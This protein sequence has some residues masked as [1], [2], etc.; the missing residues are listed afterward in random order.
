MMI[1]F[2]L[3]GTLCDSKP[4]IQHSLACALVQSGYPVPSDSAIRSIIGPPFTIG[5]PRIGVRSEDIDRVI[6]SYR[7]RYQ[8]VGAFEN[9][10]YPGIEDVLR[11]LQSEGHQLA[12]ATSKPEASA[13]PIL[14]HFNLSRY[15]T[16]RAGATLDNSRSAKADVIQYALNQFEARGQQPDDAGWMIG[17]R[18]HD[19]GG[20]IRHNLQSIGVTW[21]YGTRK[22]LFEAGA[23][24]IA[25]QPQDLLAILHH[26]EGPENSVG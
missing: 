26:A 6:N 5:L 14:D 8:D 21:G 13:F 18:H 24:A 10:V 25:D 3:D 4:G 7:A 16:V 23:V 9:S 12:V 2:D 11:E 15:F 20:A 19:V 17:D 22:E 1:F